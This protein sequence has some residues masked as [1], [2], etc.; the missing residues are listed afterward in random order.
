M[1][2]RALLILATMVLVGMLLS[3]L[4]LAVTKNCNHN[5]KGT[6]GP[7]SLIGSNSKNKLHALGGADVVKG[8]RG[9]DWLYG[10]GGT[11]E[12][13][14]GPGVDGIYGGTGYDWLNGKKGSD[15]LKDIEKSGR[16]ST[17]LHKQR[18]EASAKNRKV[19]VLIGDRGNDTIRARDGNRDII[20]GGPG[21]DKAYVDRVDKVTGVEK[22]VVPGG[23]GTG[24]GNP[25]PKPN[26]VAP[27]KTQC[28]D[29]KD[30]DGDGKTDLQDSGCASATDDTENSNTIA[31]QNHPPVAQDDLYCE[32]VSDG[33]MDVG[34]PGVLGNDT[35]ADNQGNTN[36]GLTVQDA[37]P[38]TTKIDP[39]SGPEGLLELKADGSFTYSAD[40]SR[41]DSFTYKAT[42]GADESNE[43]TVSIKELCKK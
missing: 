36:A 12:L 10:E 9:T 42:D 7:D 30:N 43:V 35:D 37:D 31:P 28:E 38:N 2:L 8:L 20:R 40:I 1:K 33:F 23:G 21:Y 27:Q 19:D 18:I 34:P 25:Q 5:C 13:S 14:G 24:G 41:D 32:W 17:A 3:G 4:V 22:E 11:D 16:Y 29:G 26:P 39:V 6:N 15:Y